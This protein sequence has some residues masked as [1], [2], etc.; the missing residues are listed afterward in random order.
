MSSPQT[1]D[2]K[3]QLASEQPVLSESPNALT[4]EQPSDSA[5]LAH[6]LPQGSGSIDHDRIVKNDTAE[7]GHRPGGMIVANDDPPAYGD[8]NEA[9]RSA[10]EGLRARRRAFLRSVVLVV[11]TLLIGIYIGWFTCERYA[12]Q[13]HKSG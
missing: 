2:S 7:V 8:D 4:N 3:T 11:A 5:N 12:K 1:S 13:A 9:S 6:D 10:A